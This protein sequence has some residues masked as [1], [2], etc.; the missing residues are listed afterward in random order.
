MSRGCAAGSGRY[1]DTTRWVVE[2]GGDQVCAAGVVSV[3]GLGGMYLKAKGGSTIN[4]EWRIGERDAK[5]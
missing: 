2:G 1:G 4:R 3:V 5:N